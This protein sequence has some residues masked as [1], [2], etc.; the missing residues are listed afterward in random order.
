MP[1]TAGTAPI[2]ET[3]GGPTCD[4]ACLCAPGTIELQRAPVPS[5]D[6]CPDGSILVRARFASICGS[7]IP[8]FKKK[9]M[10]SASSYWNTPGFCGHECVG[11]VVATKSS[12]FAVGDAVLALPPSYFQAHAG[13][14]Q[15]WFG[16]SRFGTSHE[17]LLK[18]F[19]VRGA[20]T[21][22]FA[23]HE[24]Y[25][26]KLSELKQVSAGAGGA[27]GGGAG[28]GAGTAAAAAAAAPA[29][30]AAARLLL[31]L[32]LTIVDVQE[33]I[34]A[35]GLG[36]MLRLF[37]KMPPVMNKDVAVLGCGQNGL[38]AVTL[39]S[40][41]L[42]KSV[43]AIEPLQ[44][45]RAV[46]L[47]MG[48]TAAISPEEAK[49]R[50]YD[51]VIEMVGH[52]QTS[53]ETAIDLV[54]ASGVVAAFGVPDD[55]RYDF[56]YARA[57]ACFALQCLV[58]ILL[59]PLTDSPPPPP[60][61]D[62]KWFRKNINMIASVCPHPDVDFVQAVELLESGRIDL[63]PVLTHVLP[64]REIQEAFR[65]SSSYDD[66]CIKVVVDLAPTPPPKKEEE[67]LTRL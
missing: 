2:Q 61:R 44:N 54:K 8:F 15:E 52:C 39:S 67:I 11:E 30:A 50:G 32:L 36:T 49:E 46:A 37:R 1:D 59:L 60:C 31:P 9:Q 22:T 3:T 16:T 14:R 64:L 56:P 20:F 33:F 24:I 26:V 41:M 4:A 58:L 17:E 48:A 40:M 34:C 23:G 55:S 5:L 18:P 53:I 66:G 10:P 27:D 62:D 29:A 45:R 38:I 28:A 21:N 43:T 19:P 7:D 13:M 6:D 25:S 63:S 42:A 57:R 47:K 51:V 35:Q 65:L 12:H